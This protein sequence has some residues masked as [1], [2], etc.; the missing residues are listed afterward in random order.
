MELFCDS[1]QAS[2]H[3]KP[4]PCKPLIDWWVI[5]GARSSCKQRRAARRIRDRPIKKCDANVSVRAAERYVR[6]ALSR[7]P[8]D[9]ERHLAL[10]WSSGEVQADFEEADFSA[11]GVCVRLGCFVVA[12]PS[13]I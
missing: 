5:D 9:T 4:D 3:S 13:Q 2:R 7:M 1:R 8:A 11:R 12:S 10:T 6:A